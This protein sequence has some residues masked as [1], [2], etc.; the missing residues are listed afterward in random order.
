[1]R[2]VLR[3]LPFLAAAAAVIAVALPP[4]SWCLSPG[5]I[6]ELKKAGVEDQTIELIIR[7]QSD[8]TG[9]I[10]VPEVVRMKKAGV[11]D[12]V[13]RALATPASPHKEVRKY[14]THVDQIKE[15]STKD[16]IRLKEAG[17][18][19]SLLEAVIRMQQNDL[20]PYLFDMGIVTCP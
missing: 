13:I 1:M 2:N 12:S 10:S 20:F 3:F 14:G 5:D 16:L 15:I 19:D 8:L 17:F 6:I 4:E 9:S 18:D 11:S 7:E